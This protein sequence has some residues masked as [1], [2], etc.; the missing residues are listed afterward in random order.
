MPNHAPC[1]T[2]PRACGCPSDGPSGAWSAAI[3]TGPSSSR[4]R[5]SSSCSSRW[6]TRCRSGRPGSRPPPRPCCWARSSSSRPR[7][8][9]RRPRGRRELAMALIAVVGAINLVSLGLLVHYLVQ[10]GH[11]EGHALIFSG[12]KLLLTNVLLFA[13]WFWELDRGGPVARFST[14]RC[15]A[16]LP[17]PPDG[18]PAVRAEGLAPGVLRLPLHVADE[19]ERVQPDRHDAAHAHGEGDHGD[20]VGVVARHHRARAG[21]GGE[22]PGV[23]D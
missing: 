23:V 20:R 15:A 11:A 10:G 5:S 7:A 19:R 18:R 22:H 6:S 3:P 17:L 1:P 4:S 13:V 9:R 12:T 16:G 2:P 21:P 8:R 14:R